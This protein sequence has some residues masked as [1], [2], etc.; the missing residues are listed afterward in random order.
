MSFN[1]IC[2]CGSGIVYRNCCKPYISGKKN[3]PTAEA[4]MRSRYTAYVKHA[5]DYIVD[6]CLEK[7]KVNYEGIKKWSEGSTWLGFN[8]ISVKCGN[9]IDDTVGKIIFEA[10]YETKDR[11]K[12]VHHESASFVKR[13]GRWLY[14]DGEITPQ[15]VVR[16]GEKLGR[17]DPCPCRS[18]KKYKH[19]CGRS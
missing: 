7:G 14:D 9:D 18:G 19:C 17:N 13:D 3:A 4:L 8:I 1:E 2:P 11:L 6:T 16:S 5:I 12:N 10:T 15:T